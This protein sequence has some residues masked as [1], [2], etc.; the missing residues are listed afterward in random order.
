L[1]MSMKLWRYRTAL[2][3]VLEP[4]TSWLSRM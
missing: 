4:S 3:R 2:V 1:F